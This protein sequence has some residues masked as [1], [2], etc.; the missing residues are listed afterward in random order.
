MRSS[1]PTTM[2]S[3]SASWIECSSISISGGIGTLGARRR[4]RSAPRGRRGGRRRRG[5]SASS[6]IGSCSGATPAPN[7]S[8]S[9]SRVRANDARSRSSLLTKIAAREPELVGHAPH[10]LGLHLDALDR[11]HH[12]H[13]EVGGT[14]RGGDVADEV[15]VP[16]GVDHVDLVAVVLERGDGQRHRD[17]PPRLLGVEVGDGVAVLD[18]AETG[19]RPGGEEQRLGERRLARSAV[20]H[21][22]DVADLLGRE[23]LGRHRPTPVHTCRSRS[24]AESTHGRRRLPGAKGPVAGGP[25]RYGRGREGPAGWYPGI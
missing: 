11:G 23:R 19:D 3:M 2:P 10:D 15:G 22:G 17:P 25:G 1:S 16:G 5:S 14:Q 8:L 18:L 4:R 13:R 21:E 6:P 9:W 7:L 12:E 24:S 20:A